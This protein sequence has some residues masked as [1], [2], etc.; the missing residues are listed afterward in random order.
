MESW[1]RT[2]R[3]WQHAFF[4]SW[5]VLTSAGPLTEVGQVLP[6]ALVAGLAAWYAVWFVLRTPP[7]GE[8]P[9]PYVA[10][11]ALLCLGLFAIDRSFLVVCL[12]VLVP[13][14]MDA[15]RIGLVA[16]LSCAGGWLWHSYHHGGSISWTEIAITVLIAVSAATSVGYFSSVARQSAERKELID[17][18]QA[19]QE[20]RAAA[21]RQ[22]G[23]AAERQ[24]LAR[25]IHD[26][27]TQGFAS[28]V[29]LLEAAQERSPDDRH[30]AQ[31]LCT[32]RE[33]LVESRRV[34]RALRPGEL[35]D[36]G[37]P[38]ALRRLSGRL[39]DETGIDAHAVITGPLRPLDAQVQAELLRVAQEAVAN[40]R[41]HAG[42]GRVTLTLSYM[43]DLVVLDVHDD[44][45][46]FDPGRAAAG[47]GLLIMSERMAQLGGTLLV[48]SA[49][50]E[51]TTVVAS[52]PVAAR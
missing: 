34:V 2:R 7:A 35:D 24:R 43:E 46:G 10:G 39:S 21:E 30:L 17:Q 1:E 6:V 45:D 32:A 37:L 28:V 49:A 4:G 20:A 38:E 52:L 14:C 11:G 12:C 44:G 27:L 33:N 47:H 36:G 26:S 18:L 16:V 22:A 25:D 40:A 50:G 48:E 42:A 9:L 23:V 41:R 3:R 51:G 31:A 5:L 8:V 15:V 13:Y 19:A 29:M